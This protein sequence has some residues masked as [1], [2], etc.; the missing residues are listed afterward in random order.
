MGHTCHAVGG[1]Q[2]L[3]VGGLDANPPLTSGD[4]ELIIKRTFNT[5]DPFEQGLAVFDKQTLQFKDVY[6]ASGLATYE[7]SDEV[8]RIN[9]G[10]NQSV[11][12][13]NF[14]Q[15]VDTQAYTHTEMLPFKSQSLSF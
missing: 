13:T 1:S 15:R 4:S 14:P 5:K 9:G 8:Q 6:T 7:Q 3:I 10:S 2:I 12:L 11:T